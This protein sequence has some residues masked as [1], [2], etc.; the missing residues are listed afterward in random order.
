MELG[1]YPRH[2]QAPDFNA[3]LVAAFK[4]NDNEFSF[5]QTVKHVLHHRQEKLL[6]GRDKL[7]NYFDKYD[8]DRSGELSMPEIFAMLQ[9]LNLNFQTKEDQDSVK[10][11][12]LELVNNGNG[13]IDCEA[14]KT[15][16]LRI[17]EQL[18]RGVY[19]Q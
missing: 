1:L 2:S 15:I 5:G 6:K 13:M 7:N 8:K 19:S 11:F 9:E 12:F 16:Y 3:E 10:E 17:D 4:E 18:R 14:F